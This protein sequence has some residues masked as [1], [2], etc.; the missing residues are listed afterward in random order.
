MSVVRVSNGSLEFFNFV[1]SESSVSNLIS[2][3][4]DRGISVK[5][6]EVSLWILEIFPRALRTNVKTASRVA[7]PAEESTVPE[8]VGVVVLHVLNTIVILSIKGSVALN[9]LRGLASLEVVSSHVE[10]APSGNKHLS[11]KK[12]KV[13]KESIK[14]SKIQGWSTYK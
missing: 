12:D 4:V 1:W 13:I 14:Q 9:H 6:G 3:A 5:L 10:R 11:F 8:V 2:A 7:S